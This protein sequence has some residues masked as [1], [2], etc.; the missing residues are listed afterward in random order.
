MFRLY[1]LPCLP[2]VVFLFAKTFD[3]TCDYDNFGVA[4][5]GDASE[6]ADARPFLSDGVEHVSCDFQWKEFDEE[7]MAVLNYYP[8]SRTYEDY[9]GIDMVPKRNWEYHS[10]GELLYPYMQTRLKKWEIGNNGPRDQKNTIKLGECKVPQDDGGAWVVG[11]LG[12]F[13]SNG[14]YDW[15]Q[16]GI[17][18]VFRFSEVLKK[19]PE[20]VYFSVTF[21]GVVQ[22]DGTILGYPPIHM[23][24]IH[25]T[26][27]PGVKKKLP[28]NISTYVV[29]L[30]MEQH[31]DYQCLPQD[32]GVNC[33]FELTP[34]GNV[35][36]IDRVMD[37]EGELNDVRVPNS[38]TLVWYYQYA[39]RWHPKSAGK[40]RPL[41]QTFFVKAEPH[42]RNQSKEVWDL[43]KKEGPNPAFTQPESQ[44]EELSTFDLDTKEYTIA[45]G[46][47]AMMTTGDLVRNKIHS[48][49]VMFDRAFWFRA[50]PED[51]GLV[52]GKTSFPFHD[53]YETT[54][55]RD[56]GF[57]NFDDVETYLMDNLAEA[58]RKH[59]KKCS[60]KSSFL[61]HRE[62]SECSFNKPYMVCQVTPKNALVYDETLDKSFLF[63]RRA[64]TCC[65]PWSWAYGEVWTTV[66]FFR[67]ITR[68]LGPWQN[69]IPD[70]YPQHL[71]WVMTY[72][73][74]GPKARPDHSYY[75]WY[76]YRPV[77]SDWPERVMGDSIEF[78]LVDSCPAKKLAEKIATQQMWP[79]SLYGGAYDY[80]GLLDFSSDSASMMQVSLEHVALQDQGNNIVSRL[81]TKLSSQSSAS[82]IFE[83]AAIVFTAFAL[84]R[85]SDKVGRFRKVEA[86]SA[87]SCVCAPP[88]CPCVRIDHVQ[89][90]S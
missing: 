84:M 18:D 90:D 33:F 63:D 19:H 50:S 20:G 54:H 45:W 68:A 6:S 23:H 9:Y 58:A 85:L 36:E 86:Y 3:D 44:I 73:M 7:S 72:H 51:L 55:L 52:G 82:Q 79:D 14:G 56:T 24:H 38:E 48:H 88:C 74:T 32:G 57:K 34:N 42:T 30:A 49:N 69:Y 35:K 2:G 66:G 15:W 70:V 25:V 61:Q 76:Q 12:P 77:G 65:K 46:T 67:P 83:L 40:H 17:R 29:N 26:P 64:K 39:I 1:L 41:S 60:Q 53:Y 21:T 13:H 80:G 59:E 5:V 16:L 10:Q 47:G 11:R 71:H 89:K 37:L 78:C 75:T 31:G 27:Q 62:S 81:I 87:V 43:A 4:G 28:K 22:E 8:D